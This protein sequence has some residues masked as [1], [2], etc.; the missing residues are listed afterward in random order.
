MDALRIKGGGYSVSRALGPDRR[1]PGQGK[2]PALILSEGV[3]QEILYLL[4]F[5]NRVL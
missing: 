1:L 3:G 5:L 2:A 4:S